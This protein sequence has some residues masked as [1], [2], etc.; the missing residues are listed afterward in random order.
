[1]NVGSLSFSSRPDREKN[2]IYKINHFQEPEHDAVISA[3]D[4]LKKCSKIKGSH[5]MNQ[6]TQ[7]DLSMYRFGEDDIKAI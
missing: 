4:D 1:M 2:G 6:Q 5:N 3:I 7:R